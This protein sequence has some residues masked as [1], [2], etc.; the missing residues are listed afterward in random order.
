MLP[1]QALL[2][3]T[4]WE[5]TL[6]PSGT[7]MPRPPWAVSQFCESVEGGCTDIEAAHTSLAITF[8]ETIYPRLHEC[9]QR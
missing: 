3:K 7:A 8:S 4:I 5:R 1:R 6:K 2:H 9:P